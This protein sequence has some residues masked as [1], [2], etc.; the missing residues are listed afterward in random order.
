MRENF[1]SNH[2]SGIGGH[3]LN[4]QAGGSTLI[5]LGLT[6]LAVSERRAH[7][8][9]ETGHYHLIAE[10][11]DECVMKTLAEERNQECTS[12]FRLTGGGA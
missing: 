7:R 5:W 1:C 4:L 10:T 9:T 11:I 3:G 6:E 2:P 12:S 8:R